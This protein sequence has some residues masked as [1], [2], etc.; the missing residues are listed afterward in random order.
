MEVGETLNF[1]QE[2]NALP[3]GLSHLKSDKPL[4]VILPQ[5]KQ[6]FRNNKIINNLNINNNND[7]IVNAHPS[8]GILSY[9]CPSG[10]VHLSLPSPESP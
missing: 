6:Q 10:K 9:N 2:P 7:K 1:L 5:L 3:F 8:R 4:I